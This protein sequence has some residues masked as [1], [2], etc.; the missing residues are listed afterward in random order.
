MNGSKDL[1]A[2]GKAGEAESKPASLSRTR[3]LVEKAF[4]C[5]KRSAQSPGKAHLRY[6]RQLQRI[7]CSRKSIP[8]T[9]PKEAGYA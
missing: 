4:D 1:A 8:H 3:K 7:R 9:H 2:G 5:A 6:E